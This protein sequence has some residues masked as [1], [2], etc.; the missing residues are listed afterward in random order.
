MLTTADITAGYRNDNWEGFGYLGERRNQLAE[1][2]S[3]DAAD[4][5][6]LAAANKAGMDEVLFFQWLNSKNGRWFGDCV[7]GNNGLHA[8]RYVPGQGQF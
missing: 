4:A 6:V 2:R 1:G 3:V 8:E 7:F 5:M